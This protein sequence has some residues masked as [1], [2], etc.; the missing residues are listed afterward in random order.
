MG[1]KTKQ[2]IKKEDHLSDCCGA[3]PIGTIVDGLAICLRCKQW[4]DF[5]KLEIFRD[6]DED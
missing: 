4:A 1:N 2:K 3:P 6:D 5:D